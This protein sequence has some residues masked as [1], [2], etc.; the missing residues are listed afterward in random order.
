M[1]LIG[2]GD[3]RGALGSLSVIAIGQPIRPHP[4]QD[5][6]HDDAQHEQDAPPELHE[7]PD[8]QQ[9]REQRSHGSPLTLLLAS[10]FLIQTPVNGP[11]FMSTRVHRLSRM[12]LRR[13]M[14]TDANTLIETGEYMNRSGV[15]FARAAQAVP[16]NSG[17]TTN[18]HRWPN[19]I[20]RWLYWGGGRPATL[21]RRVLSDWG[22]P[23]LS[24]L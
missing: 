15:R 16:T 17:Y 5:T 11:R 10:T 19:E 6:E 7:K 13:T 14:I 23:A 12:M 21:L 20:R 1:L 22:P 9:R 8:Q 18:R 4:E 3:Q 24:G 2:P